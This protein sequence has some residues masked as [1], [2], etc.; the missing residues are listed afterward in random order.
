MNENNEQNE[1]FFTIEKA[2]K[3]QQFQLTFFEN[4]LP[5]ELFARLKNHC[6]TENQKEMKNG[7]EVFRGSDIDEWLRKNR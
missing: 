2:I 4:S 7:Y 3:I 6:E 5:Q 1:D